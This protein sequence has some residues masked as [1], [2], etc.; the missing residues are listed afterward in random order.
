MI[1]IN[2]AATGRLLWK[3]HLI[4]S[5]SFVFYLFSFEIMT[6]GGFRISTKLTVTELI[7]Q[8]Q[9]HSMCQRFSH[10][11]ISYAFQDQQPISIHEQDGIISDH[12]ANSGNVDIFMHVNGSCPACLMDQ[13]ENIIES[14]RSQI[15][16]NPSK[17]MQLFVKN[18]YG[19]TVTVEAFP[20]DT[21]EVLKILI[22]YREAIPVSYQRLIS[23]TRYLQNDQT[24]RSYNIENQSNVHLSVC[25]TSI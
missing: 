21:V 4:L 23:A 12:I 17:L 20:D 15:D 5:E 13:Y 25:W 9:Q 14:H 3:L 18:L 22:Y 6:V 2:I 19:R 11:L 8:I 16:K 10:K 24:L 1:V 7:T